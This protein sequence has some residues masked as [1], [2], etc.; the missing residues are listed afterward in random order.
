MDYYYSIL[1]TSIRNTAEF[2]LTA[3]SHTAVDVCEADSW[4]LCMDLGEKRKD[5]TRL[6]TLV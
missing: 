6:E 3:E 5:V 4:H 2:A 1:R